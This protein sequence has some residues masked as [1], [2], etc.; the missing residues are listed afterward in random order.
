MVYTILILL[1]ILILMLIY[2][3][4]LINSNRN[5]NEFKDMKFEILEKLMEKNE[6][7]KEDISKLIYEGKINVTSEIND[8]K[9]NMKENITKDVL[10]LGDKV[11]N[12]LKDGF[13]ISNEAVNTVINR[14]VKIDETQK[15]IEK[16]S[17]EV[18]SL[19]K[20]LSDKKSRGSF[21][22]TRLEQVLGYVYGDNNNLYERQYKFSNG[23]VADAVL[24][25]NTKLNKV[26]IDSKFPL[27]NYIL[28]SENKNVEYR[29]EFIK[30]LKKHI[31][32]ISS[33]YII[34]GETINQAIMFLPSESI[35]IDIYS[36][37]PEIL[38]YAYSK[39]VWIASQTNLMIYITTMQFST[40]EYKR[41]ENAKEILNQLDRFSKEFLRY[42]DRWQNL[43]KDFKRLEKDFNDLNITSDKI[44]K[45]FEK[46]KN[47]IDINE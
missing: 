28:Y 21:G 14:L 3:I 23:K 43:N 35:F 34:I 32:D 24:F 7:S 22:E 15:N 19:Q 25:L 47:L 20:I 17:T 13:K 41:N 6:R 40:I 36:E 2:L 26:A 9:L 39:R 38:E 16:L 46:I 12:V 27:E 31:D 30:D 1:V 42:N 11:E 29:K 18:I 45:E 37:F 44:A 4:Y 10:N 8:F 33:K 5:N